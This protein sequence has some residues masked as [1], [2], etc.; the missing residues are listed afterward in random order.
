MTWEGT[1]VPFSVQ[2][3]SF[4]PPS[5]TFS[6]SRSHRESSTSLTGCNEVRAFSMHL[7]SHGM[8]PAPS[9]QP[10]TR[11]ISDSGR[12]SNIMTTT[13]CR[14][15]LKNLCSWTRLMNNFFVNQI[16]TPDTGRRPMETPDSHCHQP[17]RS[18]A[19]IQT[20]R[21]TALTRQKQRPGLV[22]A[23]HSSPSAPR[24]TA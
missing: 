2:F 20:S 11:T 12:R 24:S 7:A 21:M 4:A 23:Y 22:Q 18:T 15:M 10:T 8:S 6:S 19:L 1:T 13:T 16:R 3:L 9:T 14:G 5:P 17:D